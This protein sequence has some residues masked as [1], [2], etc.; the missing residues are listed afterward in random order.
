MSTI[1]PAP[2][3]SPTEAQRITV[4]VSKTFTQVFS[5]KLDNTKYLQRKQQ[6][7]G[8]LRGTKIF[9]T[10]HIPPIF[11]N[12]AYQEEGMKILHILNRKNNICSTP[13]GFCP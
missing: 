1:Q 10:M 12:N 7:Q 9:E 3:S 4:A 5:V 8:V 2:S 6:V 13:H 11:L